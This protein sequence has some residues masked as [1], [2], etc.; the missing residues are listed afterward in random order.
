MLAVTNNIKDIVKLREVLKHRDWKS[1]AIIMV[2]QTLSCLSCFSFWLFLSLNIR[3]TFRFDFLIE[4][5]L[6]FDF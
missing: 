1:S 6:Y 5:F 4:M 3:R 2:L